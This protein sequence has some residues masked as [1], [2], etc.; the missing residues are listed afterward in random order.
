MSNSRFL[1]R[2][3]KFLLSY[4]KVETLFDMYGLWAIHFI[5][6]ILE[7]MDVQN[8]LSLPEL[9]GEV[10]AVQYIAGGSEN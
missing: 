7:E 6:E 5:L 2:I 3:W 1:E 8:D 10:G 9:A 4:K